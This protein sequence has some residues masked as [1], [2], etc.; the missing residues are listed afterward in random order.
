MTPDA[1]RKASE[2]WLAGDPDAGTRAELEELLR[3]GDTAELEERFAHPVGFGT[4]GLRALLGAGP[5][6]RNCADVRTATAGLARWLREA[7][8][9]PA[10]AEALAARIKAVPLT[11][12]G[13]QPLA[14]AISTAGWIAAPPMRRRRWRC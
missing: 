5:A 11:L 9:I 6:R 14:R 1:L 12:T 13:V 2:E 3:R 8:E 4:A 10:G 7:G